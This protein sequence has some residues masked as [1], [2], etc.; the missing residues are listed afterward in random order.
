MFDPKQFSLFPPPVIERRAEVHAGT[1]FEFADRPLLV[2]KTY[3]NDA[4]AP[5]ICEELAEF[6]TTLRGQYA[7]WSQDNVQRAMA[8]RGRKP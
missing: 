3:G 1:V 8:A 7:L 4:A 6:G 2:V 5:V